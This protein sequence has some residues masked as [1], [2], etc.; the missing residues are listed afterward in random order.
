MPVRLGVSADVF[1]G[2]GGG[3]LG[4]RRHVRPCAG[5]PRLS[6]VVAWKTWMAGTGLAMTN[7]GIRK[8][9]LT[10]PLRGDPLPQGEMV[11]P[12]RG[13]GLPLRGIVLVVVLFLAG[14]NLLGDQPRIRPH[15]GFDLGGDVGVVLQEGLGVL[16]PLPDTL[17]VIG[18]P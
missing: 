10:P 16:A 14:Q 2:G 3:S 8:R 12:A 11:T 4:T 15:G 5:H 13:R 7:V 9:P 17:T 1:S 18:E 6:N